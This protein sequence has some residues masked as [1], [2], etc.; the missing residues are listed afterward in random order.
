MTGMLKAFN[1]SLNE[2]CILGEL[3]GLEVL[4]VRSTGIKV[5]PK[6]IGELTNLRLLDAGD[7]Y[8]LFD[9]TLGVISK[10]TWLEELY[11]GTDEKNAMS[12]LGLTEISNLKSIRALHLSMNSD[13]CHIFP[14]GTY[15]EKLKEFFFSIFGRQ[16]FF[17]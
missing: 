16:K 2:I 6:E 15:F 14:E 5:I 12:C 3:K 10:L 1:Q 8:Y 17:F 7:C 13:G 9:V 11:I 4:K